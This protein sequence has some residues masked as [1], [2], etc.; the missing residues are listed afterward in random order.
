M[1]NGYCFELGTKS[2]DLDEPE[3]EIR[4]SQIRSVHRRD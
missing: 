1:V 4:G 3:C 2:C